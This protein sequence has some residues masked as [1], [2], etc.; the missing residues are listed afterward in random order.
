MGFDEDAVERALV[1]GGSRERA[2]QLLLDGDAVGGGNGDNGGGGGGGDIGSE[3]APPATPHTSDAQTLSLLARKNELE[4]Q[5]QQHMAAPSPS[6]A[7]SEEY[8]RVMAQYREVSRALEASGHDRSRGASAGGAHTVGDK[9][10][11]RRTDGTESVAY[12]IECSPR[13][14]AYKVAIDA[15]D[16]LQHKLVGPEHLRPFRDG[17]RP[18]TTS[19]ATTATTPGP[20][21]AA[22][23][24]AHASASGR[25][26][27]CR[28]SDRQVPSCSNQLRVQSS[29]AYACPACTTRFVVNLSDAPRPQR[30]GTP[31]HDRQRRRASALRW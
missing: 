5:L 9:V 19:A 14:D 10:F 27:S 1:Q 29:G 23:A 7:A 21:A 20:S 30:T 13:G 17:E 16:S 18:L 12:V 26:Q 11:V 31:T 6:P 15:P 25:C 28:A 8:S 4:A 3:R 24:G 22:A 2:L